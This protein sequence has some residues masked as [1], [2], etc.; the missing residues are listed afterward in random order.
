MFQ[1]P[2]FA[3]LTGWQIFNLP[4]CPIRKSADQ[5]SF[6]T[7][8]SL[9]QL[10]TSFFADECQ[11][12]HHLPFLCSCYLFVKN[13]LS[14]DNLSKTT[15]V[16]TDLSSCWFY[17]TLSKNNKKSQN[18][19]L[20]D[21]ASTLLLN[22][23]SLLPAVSSRK[24]GQNSEKLPIPVKTLTHFFRLFF[25]TPVFTR[26]SKLFCPAFQWLPRGKVVQKYNHF[27]YPQDFTTIF[28]RENL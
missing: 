20:S 26:S 7:P 5:S 4:G 23:S 18:T 12:I 21:T 16:S 3:S 28:F 2:E 8:R 27:L 11:G 14:I 6:A 1:F 25:S 19:L 15:F 9:S 22:A 17:P 10:T 13:R 24:R